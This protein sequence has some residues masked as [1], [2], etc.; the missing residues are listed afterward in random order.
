MDLPWTGP[1][2][3]WNIFSSVTVPFYDLPFAPASKERALGVPLPSGARGHHCWELRAPFEE[4]SHGQQGTG[5]IP[6]LG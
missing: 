3:L 1:C 2:G 4:H 5:L 6:A